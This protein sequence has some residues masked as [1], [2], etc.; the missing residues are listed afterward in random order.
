MFWAENRRKS[1]L[2]ICF[3]FLEGHDLICCFYETESQYHTCFLCNPGSRKSQGVSYRK[4]HKPAGLYFQRL[5]WVGCPRFLINQNSLIILPLQCELQLNF[6]TWDN[7]W[8]YRHGVIS[9]DGLN[10]SCVHNLASE[11]IC[12]CHCNLQDRLSIPVPWMPLP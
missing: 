7:G 5:V 1:Q 12:L 4:V 9:P 8:C 2:R 6:C 3:Q 10:K 11:E